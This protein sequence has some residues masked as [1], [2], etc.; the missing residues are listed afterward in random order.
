MSRPAAHRDPHLLTPEGAL[1]D[2]PVPLLVDQPRGWAADRIQALGR[3]AEAGAVVVVV[4]P[5]AEA[6]WMDLLGIDPGPQL[7]A[8]EVVVE[9]AAHPV[10]RNVVPEHVV[11]GAFRSWVPRSGSDA[12][13]TTRLHLGS[14]GAVVARP[15]GDGLLVTS[16]RRAGEGADDPFA[17]VLDRLWRRAGVPATSLGVGVI[18]YGQHGGMGWLHGTAST[19]VEGLR[20]AAV[21][22]LHP[23]R[24]AEAVE[25]F[26]D[27]TGYEGAD[28]LLADASV[29]VV[30]VATPPLTHHQIALDALRAGKHVV[31]EKPLCFTAVQADELL[32][33]ADDADRLLTVHQNRRWDADYRAIRRVIES[34]RLGEVFNVE[35]FVGG[36]EHPCRLWH[37]DIGVSGGRLYDWGA[38]LI[39]QTLQLLGGRQPVEVVA[40]G[41]KRV[42]HD[43]TNLDQV[44]VRMRFD[45][46]VEA[47]F[48]DS[49]VL[50]VRRPKYVVQGSA[51]TLVGRYVPVVEE[52]VTPD[53][54]YE[55]DE[56]HHAEGPARLSLAVHQPGWG[57]EEVSVPGLPAA[58]H[59]FH[60]A[61]A[62][63]LQ[64]GD[65]VPVDAREIRDVTAVLEAAHTSAHDGGRA[66]R[67]A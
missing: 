65:P 42:W 51:G 8:G 4:D 7:S 55:R 14:Q 9:P 59:G 11:V 29:E 17:V 67:P 12:V 24:R 47:E 2:G 15:A 58:P 66:V 32:A 21:A 25:R 41:H 36:F 57:L 45:D 54:G 34:G 60:R 19:A 63:H 6:A 50:A 44:R 33:A 5:P 37:S 64:L 13:L 22:E 49:D 38:H 52:R 53:R 56:H 39:D 62:D 30:V 10:A 20:L 1:P 23:G 28:A 3:H 40:T 43:V 31:V 16:A 48:L 46:G 18:G 35:T 27:A 26:P 61:L